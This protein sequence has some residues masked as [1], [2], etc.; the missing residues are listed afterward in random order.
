MTLGGDIARGQQFQ[1]LCLRG[2]WQSAEAYAG[3]TLVSGLVAPGFTFNGCELAP[4]GWPP[5]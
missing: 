1:A 2:C 5:D 3:C 4:S